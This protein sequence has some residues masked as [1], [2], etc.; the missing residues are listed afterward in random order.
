[1]GAVLTVA[2]ERRLVRGGGQPYAGGVVRETVAAG[3]IEVAWPSGATQTVEAGAGPVVHV[4]EPVAVR[5]EPRRA[6]PGAFVAI[7]VDG[8]AGP[9][10]LEASAGAILPL[11]GATP[12]KTRALLATP[13]AP[14]TIVI[15]VTVDGRPLRI[16]PRVFVR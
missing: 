6:A 14:A 16:R 15:T 10:Q 12:G 1:V 13:A 11:P 9:V 8:A 5:V 4:F 2:G 7:E 3:P